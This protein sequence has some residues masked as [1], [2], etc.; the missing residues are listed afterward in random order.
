MVLRH[1]GNK[2]QARQ[3]VI[4]KRVAASGRVCFQKMP[5]STDA[6]MDR[7]MNISQYIGTYVLQEKGPS[8][9]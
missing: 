8:Y 3:S 5:C 2:S 7:P 4:S 1:T 9:A 6:V